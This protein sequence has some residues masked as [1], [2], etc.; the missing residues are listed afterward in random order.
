MAH[1]AALLLALSALLA[2]TGELRAQCGGAG[3][4]VTTS[5]D[6][7]AGAG[8]SLRDAITYANANPGTTITFSNSIANQTITLTSEL[9]LVL[10]NNTTINGG[11]NNVTLS[12][13][14]AFRGFFIGD[15]G[16]T[17]N[18]PTNAT[19]QNLTITQTK[20]VGGAGANLGYAAGG[21]GAGMGGAIFVSSTGSVSVANLALTSNQAV[22]GAG[23][24]SQFFGGYAGGGGMGGNGNFGGGGFGTGANG[25]NNSGA[26][27]GSPGLFPG[28]ASGG[29]G[30][31]SGTTPG[32]SGGANGGGGGSGGQGGGG[33]GVGGG[34]ASNPP[35]PGNTGVGGDGGFGG[36]G[37]A[38]VAV[39]GNGGYG[40]G[41]GGGSSG[42][43]GGFGG[44]GGGVFGLAGFGGGNGGG[45]AGPF[46]GTG[47]GGGAG[48]GGGIY[49][50]AGGSVN[51]TGAVTIDGTNAAT[52]GAG[53]TLSVFDNGCNCTRFGQAPNGTGLGSAIFYQGAVGSTTTM[54]ISGTSDQTI[55]G[56]IVDYIGAGGTNPNSGTNAANQGGRLAIAK[57][58]GGT[59]TLSN[60]N[61][62]S[63]GTALNAGTLVVGNDTAL[64]SGALAMA[65]GTTLS[66]SGNHI[67]SNNI[68]LTGDPTFFVDTGQTETLSGVLSDTSP[69]PNAGV[70]EKTG[71]GLLILSGANTY[72][73][74]TILSAGTLE[75]RNSTP[76]TSSSVGTGTVTMDG[77]T[78]R[79]GANN[80]SFS[81]GFALNTTGATIDTNGN[82]LA[83]TGV[84]ADGNGAGSLAKIGTGTLTLSGTNTFTGSTT[85]SGGT[86]ALSGTGSIATSSLVTVG[87]GATATFDIS[88]TT[89]GA[90]IKGLAGDTHGVV[91]L[92]NQTLTITAANAA[93]HYFGA[94]N[95]SGG[96]TIAGGAQVLDGSSTYTGVT[97][98]NN[99]ATLVLSTS[100]SIASS[101]KLVD[102]GNLDLTTT[103]SGASIKSLSG[104]NANANVLLAGGKTLTITAANNDSFAG[105][106]TGINGNVVLSGGNLALTG[107]STYTGTTTIN[108]GLL[109]VTG[110]ITGST[111]TTV[112][113]GGT[114]VVLGSLSDPTINSG[115]LLAGTGSVGDTTI[116]AG[117][118]FLPGTINAPGTSMTING[119]LAFASGAQ[120]FV[121]L[122]PSTSSFANV[123][124]TAT[125]GNATVNATF[126]NGSYVAKTYTILRAGSISGTFDPTAVNTNLPS[127]FHTALSYDGTHAYLN[128][129]LNFVPP[130]GTG[131]TGNQQG[132][133][134]A[135]SKFFN[136]NGSIPILF[137]GLTPAGLTQLSG[138]SA[139]GSQ[140]TTFSAMNQFMNV[141]TDPFIAGRGDPIGAG[142]VPNAYAEE[143]LAYAARGKGRSTSERNAYAA[144]Y[145]KAPAA[146]TFEQRWSVW[147]AGFGGTQTT[148]GNALVGSN[149]TRSSIY[150][151]AVGADYRFS[152]NTVAGFA[153]AG[154]GTNFNVNG[155]GYGRSDLFQAGA[156]VRHNIGAAY[157]SGALAYGWQ[158]V[159]TDRTV[160]VAGIDHLRAAFKANA[161]SGRLESGY[162]F[163]APIFGGL[164][165]TPYA[166]GQFTTVD[167][168]AY[169]ENVVAGSPLFALSYA[170]K[171]VTDTRSELGVRTD[172]SFAVQNGTLTLRGRFAWAHD[173]DPDRSIAT[174]F[175]ALP[176]A[177]FVVNGAAQASNAALTT[178]SAEWKWTSGWSAAAT[179]EGEFS[180]VTESYAAK[181]VVRY[182]W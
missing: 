92:G 71:V 77:G 55:G 101:S 49:V 146:A 118:M 180:N 20:A 43:R 2:W 117:G 176:S 18:G 53:G 100:G 109:L 69:G 104:T 163:V 127:G 171:S 8:T 116:N 24:G 11:A 153:L 83:L 4:V 7:L 40:G 47:G 56:T 121:S 9:P 84:I 181:G 35:G 154:G 22:G 128:L 14:N 140:Q 59:L 106:I 123:T 114:L 41:G 78:L 16:Q 173:F 33:G 87:A 108:G 107:V 126:A 166:A 63:G 26:T 149:D 148:D 129:A 93:N 91:T 13:N 182:A 99:G 28:G 119:N 88:A 125:L 38:G 27:S 6:T 179:F 151:T 157:V 54:N 165:I 169:A 64:G 17:G 1:G 94:I 46:C 76:G 137:G 152:P 111:N 39:G 65:A 95:G 67:I 162:R 120:Y 175:Q 82:A 147:A 3:C 75:V 105:K 168:P 57:S 141:L 124:G 79:A 86:L 131:L 58:G 15:A 155:L 68:G 144:M 138:E 90:S 50:Q 29:T 139:T 98:I 10:G 170:G 5:A 160:T 96:I 32:G 89:S 158:D 102:N 164:G 19:I 74:G 159:T 130:P 122:N 30:I 60:A 81:N 150:G 177:S 42:G 12:G 44:G 178:A 85:I 31:Q 62:Y 172:K 37:G 72:S 143:G 52:G 145:N 132:V 174:T 36:G 34:N 133:G 112:N 73:G 25:A 110:A 115:G 103:T 135:I 70:V 142:G 45:C 66:F 97:T 61:S 156:F 48:M 80:L 134:N 161:W 51:V 23:G 21:G 113:N 167:L 136:T